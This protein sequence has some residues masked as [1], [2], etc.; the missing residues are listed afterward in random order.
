[1][2]SVVLIAQ[3]S[4]VGGLLLVVDERAG[5]VEDSHVPVLSPKIL[6]AR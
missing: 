6:P 5:L 2:S 4:A 1:M 3:G